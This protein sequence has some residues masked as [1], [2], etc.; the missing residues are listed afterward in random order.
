MSHTSDLNYNSQFDSSPGPCTF[1][2]SDSPEISFKLPR[3]AIANFCSVRNKQAELELFLDNQD[4]HLLIGTESHLNDTIFDSEVFPRNYSVFRK[5]R[6]IHGGGV[7]ILVEKIH[8]IINS[9]DRLN[10]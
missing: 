7:F 2:N 6:N 3:L 8:T 5:D 1:D 10:L 9:R 4:I